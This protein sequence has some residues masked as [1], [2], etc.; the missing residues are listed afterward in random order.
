MSTLYFD[1][2]TT[3]LP[4]KGIPAGSPVHPHIVQLGAMLVNN[5]GRV[6]AEMNLLVKPDHWGVPDEAA[7]VHG[8]T[9]E[10]CSSYGL[11]IKSVITL[12]GRLVQRSSLLVA[13]NFEFDKMMVWTEMIRAEAATELA[14]FLGSQSFCTMEV[15]TP[16]LNLPPSQRMIAAGFN[17]PKN[18]NLKEAYAFFTNG[19]T[20]EGAHDAMADVRACRAVHQGILAYQAAAGKGPLMLDEV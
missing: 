3:G 10:M 12:F 6:V 7:K 8:I 15:S 9:T 19:G 18:P 20:F 13:H 11:P 2:E 1:T 5:E 16:I 4:A 17:K 14:A